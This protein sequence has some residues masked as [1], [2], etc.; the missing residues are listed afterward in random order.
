MPLL[1]T[2]QGAVAVTVYTFATLDQAVAKYEKRIDYTL[3]Y[4]VDKLM[5]A[6]QLPKAKGGRMPVD[7]GTLRRSLMAELNGSPLGSGA[8]AYTF[9]VGSM[10]GGD[11]ATFWWTAEYAYVVNHGRQGGAGAHFVEWA[12]DQWQRFVDEGA[13]AAIARYP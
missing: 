6:A 2:P 8:E 4:A 3:Q 5:Q 11:Y 12:A 7:T 10:K 9:V 13:K 1:E